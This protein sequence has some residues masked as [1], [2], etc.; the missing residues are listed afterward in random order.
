MS[1]LALFVV[2][3]WDNFWLLLL[4]EDIWDWLSKLFRIVDPSK[5]TTRS[6]CRSD[7]GLVNVLFGETV[8]WDGCGEGLT[9]VGVDDEMVDWAACDWE[10]DDKEDEQENLSLFE[11]ALYDTDEVDDND[12]ELRWFVVLLLLIIALLLQLL[13]FVEVGPG[14]N[15]V[16]EVKG[17]VDNF[18]KREAKSLTEGEPDDL[19]EDGLIRFELR[20]SLFVLEIVKEEESTQS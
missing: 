17:K 20:E 18:W 7:D 2:D 12:E 14:F 9:V 13:L 8:V 5:V 3:S 10:D 4:L 1:V 19:I 11:F 16:D 6:P 15:D